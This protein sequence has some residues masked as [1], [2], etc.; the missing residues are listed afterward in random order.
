MKS[1]RGQ[2][3]RLARHSRV[4]KATPLRRLALG[5]HQART[6][7]A[8][9]YSMGARA[10]M[11][12]E[13]ERWRDGEMERWRDG[14]MERWRDGEMLSL[15]W[16]AA[17]HMHRRHKAGKPDDIHGSL[18]PWVLRSRAHYRQAGPPA[19]PRHL[20]R[21]GQEGAGAKPQPGAKPHGTAAQPQLVSIP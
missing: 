15:L 21:G 3:G 1:L 11:D 9:A 5:G 19:G 14:E 20:A 2:C 10:A 4:T 18:A 6:L 7:P 13:M 8:L 16:R 12:G 17:Q